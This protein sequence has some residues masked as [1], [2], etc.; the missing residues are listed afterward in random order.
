MK[1]DRKNRKRRVKEI[2]YICV[3]GSTKRAE[4]KER[5]I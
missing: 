5:E 3:R 4:T 2:M 1:I